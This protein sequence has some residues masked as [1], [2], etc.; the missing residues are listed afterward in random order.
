MLGLYSGAAVHMVISSPGV[1]F[2]NA[3]TESPRPKMVT[4]TIIDS[5]SDVGLMS[6]NSSLVRD[7]ISLYMII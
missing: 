1:V 7:Y 2:R 5:S 3:G 6:A 4:L